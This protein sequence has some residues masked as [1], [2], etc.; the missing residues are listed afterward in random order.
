MDDGFGMRYA[1]VGANVSDSE[2]D[3]FVEMLKSMN[4]FKSYSIGVKQNSSLLV[5]TAY[6]RTVLTDAD[7]LAGEATGDTVK[8]LEGASR[9]Y[10]YSFTQS[11]D[12]EVVSGFTLSDNSEI[13][14]VLEFAGNPTNGSRI[15]TALNYQ[16]KY[17]T[18]SS[19][20]SYNQI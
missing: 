5:N 14:L 7:D 4:V 1:T 12:A 16:Q 6:S 8:T 10:S 19:G 2:A 20:Q 17:I 9:V 18:S 15:I 3:G 13:S 11:Y